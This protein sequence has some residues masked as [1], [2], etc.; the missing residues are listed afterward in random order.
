[1]GYA[2]KRIPVDKASRA[3]A[4]IDVAQARLVRRGPS[5][6][7]HLALRTLREA[8]GLTQMQVAKK[9]GIQQPDIS[10]LERASTF[11]DR[12]IAT[13]RRYLTAI[14]Q[15]LDLVAV[16]KSGHRIGV[17]GAA[18]AQDAP[19]T[20][21][22]IAARSAARLHEALATAAKAARDFADATRE[23]AEPKGWDGARRDT[24]DFAVL[25]GMLAE[26]AEG[27]IVNRDRA[28]G[29]VKCERDH[30][31][32]TFSPTRERLHALMKAALPLARHDRAKP[33][34]SAGEGPPVRP[35]DIVRDLSKRALVA[36]T[37]SPWREGEPE[38]IDAIDKELRTLN[39]AEPKSWLVRQA[40]NR[41]D[42]ETLVMSVADKLKTGGRVL[43]QNPPNDLPERL[44]RA[45]AKQREKAN[46]GTASFVVAVL[47]AYG[48]DSKKAKSLARS[49]TA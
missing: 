12:M 4:S 3:D 14:G 45:I 40:W 11:D 9:S 27:I 35:D 21:T 22:G 41:G 38:Y 30:R 34:R 47:R 2:A 29:I 6:A 49:V 24:D 5:R 26:M 18:S 17:S 42:L 32:A 48:L 39:P 13:I 31:S 43:G 15:D 8:A 16:S 7:P 44:R 33:R 20:P 23:T 28:D 25:V 36:I 37:R 46:R 1:M 19:P 10:D